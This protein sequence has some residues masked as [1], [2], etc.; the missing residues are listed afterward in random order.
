MKLFGTDGI[1]GI[2]NRFPIEPTTVVRIGKA[3]GIFLKRKN[4]KASVVIGK[5]TR[6][7]GY[8][9]EY[10]LT[11]G[12]L[13]AGADVL[14]VGPMPTPAVSHLTK[15]LNCSAG[16]VI[17]ASHNPAEHNGIKI[18]NERG[19]KLDEN[20]E[21]EIEQIFSNLNDSENGSEI[22]KAYRIDDA[23]GRYIELVKNTINNYSLEGM[24]IVIDCANGACYAIAPKVFAELGAEVFALNV[25]P[26][27]LNINKDCGALYPQAMQKE[28]KKRNADLGI[29]FD[30]D[31]DRITVCDE[32][33]SIADGDALLAIFAK[34][35]LE[36]GLLAKNAIV[37]TKMSNLALDECLRALGIKVLRTDV[38]DKYVAS[39]MREHGINLGGEQSGHI[40]FADYC[41]SPD[42]IITALQ[43]VRIIRESST[44]LSELIKLFKPYPQILINIPVREKIPFERLQAVQK[45]IKEAEHRLAGNGRVF[46]RYSGTEQLARVMLEGKNEK[47][48]KELAE[49]IA[50]AIKK[51]L[52][53]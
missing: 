35:M 45:A 52:G 34:Y 36:K 28:V 25:E 12:L 11:A 31:G 37:A 38:G 18:F 48:I 13:S 6:L 41:A 42:A 27:G 8:M 49:N 10:A 15:S 40:I 23:R 43:L 30:G 2:A 19:Y 46:V 26:N 9:I 3:I 24:R 47:E 1:R 33:G 17:S 4:P 32:K 53:A 44:P 39:A 22:G 20:A 14:L 29:A 21:Q 51:E 7:S 16:I 5:D 50:G